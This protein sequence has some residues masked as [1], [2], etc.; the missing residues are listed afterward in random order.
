MQEQLKAVLERDIR[1][2]AGETRVAQD[3]ESI[4]RLETLGYL[5][6]GRD[7]QLEFDK[8]TMD[9]K[10]FL[11]LYLKFSMASEL[12]YRDPE[13]FV[14]MPM[15]DGTTVRKQ[16]REVARKLYGDI[17]AVRPD[18]PRVRSML[19]MIAMDEGDLAAAN[20]HYTELLRLHPESAFAH[21]RLAMLR[22]REGRLDEARSLYERASTL[23]MTGQDENSGVDAI[24][25]LQQVDPLVFDIT[26]ALADLLYRQDAF[27]EA[28]ER[29]R[30]ALQMLVLSTGQVSTNQI[31]TGAQYRLGLALSKMGRNEE[32]IEALQ[33]TL[34]LQPDHRQAREAL[35]AALA[36][37]K[38]TS[39]P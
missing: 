16:R 32:A 33:K 11:P 10:D 39:P 19:G 5:D 12:A 20:E 26:I 1:T 22:S 21:E 35:D 38:G 9:K 8:T 36:A 2:F 7:V 37:D 24:L 27:D 25:Q 23:A 34:E 29:Y 28:V 15:P 13:A 6:S 31:R 17:L 3:R 30:E 4:D 18:L 14:D